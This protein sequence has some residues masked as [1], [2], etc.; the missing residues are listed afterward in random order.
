MDGRRWDP[1]GSMSR[2]VWSYAPG[3]LGPARTP[4]IDVAVNMRHLCTT[5]EAFSPGETEMAR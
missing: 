2:G 4:V 1:L 3:R 5:P